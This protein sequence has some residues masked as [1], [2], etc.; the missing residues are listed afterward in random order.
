MSVTLRFAI[1]SGIALAIAGAVGC[2][3]DSST[4]PPDAVPDTAPAGPKCSDGVDNDSDGKIDY[5]AD[6]GCVA[7]QQ[8]DEADDCPTGTSCP[9]CGNGVDDD[10]NGSTDYPND[11]GC[12]AAADPFEF[13]NNPVACGAGL[14]IKQLPSNG[15]DTGTLDASA[16]TSAITTACGGGN[17]AAAYAYQ[18]SLSAPKVIVA[19]TNGS[20]VD[21]VLDLR[22]S[23]CTTTAIECNNDISAMNRASSITRSLAAGNYYLIVQGRTATTIGDYSLE[24][25]LFAGEG[26][27][28]TATS[29]CG[30]GL[31]CRVPLGG[32]GMK[33]SKPMCSDGVDNDGDTKNDFPT[34][35]GCQNAADNDET[36]TCP[37]G[38][39]CPACGNGM[40]DDNDSAIDYPMD[41][42]CVAASGNSEACNGEVD[43]INPITAGTTTGTLV[44]AH[45]N[46]NPSC[47]GDGGLDV[48][49][50]LKLPPMRSVVIDTEGSTTDTLL[51]L[52]TATCMEPSIACDDEGGVASGA[53]RIALANLSGGTYIV[54]VNNYSPSYPPGPYTLHVTG[55]ITPGGAC[56]PADTLGGA[57]A[58]PASN[59]CGGPAGAMVCQPSACGDGMDNDGDSKMDYPAD[60]GCDTLDDIDESDTCPGAGCPECADGLDNDMDGAT[61]Y[62]M[63]S[64]CASASSSEGCPSSE[65]VMPLVMP[66]TMDTTV[67]ATND[68]RPA[69]ATTGTHTA[70]DKTYSVQIP[71]M[72]NLSIVKTT[73]T[74]SFDAVVALYDST[75]GGTALQCRNSPETIALNNLAAGQY[76]FLIDG[77]STASGAYTLT[78]SGTI[79]NGASCESSLAQNGA[80]ACATGFACRGTVGSRTCQPAACNDGLDNDAD[81]IADFPNDPGCTSTS[82][83]DEADTCPGGAGCP[84]CSD[85]M[86]NDGDLL[87]DFP[88]DPSCAAASGSSE[89]C[90]T[91]E[92]VSALVAPMTS[93]TTVGAFNDEA[94]ACGST[95]NTAPDKAYSLTVP[96]LTSL[97]ITNTNTF[98]QAVA[99]YDATCSGTAVQCKDEPETIVLAAVAA[100][101]YYYVVDG[102]GSGSGAY[103]INI[104]GVIA[105]G[106]SCESP[107]AMS[108]ALTCASGF[109]C[110]GTAGARTCQVAACGDG[111]DNDLDGKTDYPLD[112]GCASVSD[113]TEADPAV[114]PACSNSLDDDSD[115]LFDYPADY[116][117]A[118][119]GANNEAFCPAEVDPTSAITMT[120][121][122][123]TTTGLANNITTSS[124][125]PTT[126]GPDVVY[127]L[128]LPVPVAAL[129][130]D[131]STSSFDTV[132][133]LRDAQC[134]VELGCD[135]DS[136]NPTNQSSLTVLGVAA[137]N[138]SVV[139]DGYLGGNGMYNLAVRGT[140]SAGT[141]C[142]S[143]LFASGVLACIS[144]TTCTG[145]TPTCQ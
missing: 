144:G 57:L 44:G 87:I 111:M 103:S 64:T 91:S 97:T 47:G 139:I 1:A 80:I 81:G 43:P 23:N 51:S 46:H 108:G 8:D 20:V 27:A 115:S 10:G 105:T 65:S 99:L 131:L 67:G 45:D 25:S 9:Q 83:P 114:L 4:T 6:P 60:P 140:V 143:P 112:P 3:D 93:D 66:V 138:Y 5:P 42:S 129:H 82:D 38:A 54:A 73:T 30:P 40:D 52:L 120:P 90:F 74:G 109:A 122:T 49:Y 110:K 128:Q 78:V 102:Y 19:T 29:Q 141:S 56:N 71:A 26:E 84:A 11:P 85:G 130:L 17:G 14:T 36:D 107:L 28:C 55:V 119:A 13:V 106:G 134:G 21:T 22:G 136:G 75:C 101:T 132:V 7:P 121:I 98:D 100:G 116:G 94:P 63:D 137:G 117:C 16:S 72:R 24:V 61:D 68:V 95:T 15:L 12:T 133:T 48:L 124:C 62:P 18:L 104:A 96:N 142:S 69:C 53:S 145:A 76:F 41:T 33:C 31:V 126:S 92:G 59:P 35:P 58:C 89:A 123:G 32:T 127:A 118:A 2:G 88:D 135:D 50:T 113:D 70:P 34:D 77:Y 86:D 39:G 79:Q 125:E 37:S